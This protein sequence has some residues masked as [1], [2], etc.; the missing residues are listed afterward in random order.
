MQTAAA[1]AQAPTAPLTP[2]LLRFEL[3]SANGQPGGWMAFPPGTVFVDG[4]EKYGGKHSLRFERSETSPGQFSAVMVGTP[5]EFKGTT[6]ELRGWMRKE[7]EGVPSLWM[8]Q[9]AGG[10]PV[11]FIDM[12]AIHPVGAV[13]KEHSI[14]FRLQS[15]ATSLVIGVR[16]VGTGKAWADD[17]QLLVD[18]NPISEVKRVVRPRS[19]MASDLQFVGGSGLIVDRLDAPLIDALSLTGK[20][21]GF[22][23]YHH[24]FI[25]AGNKQWDFELLRRLPAIIKAPQPDAVR[26]QLVE[27]ID[28]LGPIAECKQCVL[29][30]RSN[31]HL[32][33][34]IEWI[35]DAKWLGADLSGRLQAIHR[36]RVP[37]QQFF[38]SLAPNIGNA[39]FE[40][41][42]AYAQVKFPDTGFQ[43][44][45]I[46][47]FWNMIEYWFPYRDLIDE[48][49]DAVLHD[50]L[51]RA[52]QPLDA[53]GFARELMRLAARADDGHANLEDRPSVRQPAGQCQLPLS[54]RYLERQFVVE[55]MLAHT[56]SARPFRK[57]DVIVALDGKKVAEIAREVRD[58]Y[59]ASNEFAR[60]SD[61]AM[62]LTRGECGHV[63]VRVWRDAEITLSAQRVA[64]ATL[65]FDDTT[66]NDRP[67]DTFQMLS[68]QVAYLKLST[69]AA[70]DVR[71]YL[72]S[73]ATARSL[74]VDIR[75]Y[76][77]E[78]VVYTLGNL[79]VTKP[80]QFATVTMG[81]LSDPGAFHF[82]GKTVLHPEQPGFGG[83]VLILVDE[84]SI[85]M[86]EFTAIALRAT[87]RAKVIG[88]Q[89]AG[90]DGDVSRIPMPGG[91]SAAIS[92]IGIF[93]PDRSPT[94]QVGVNLDIECP[95][96][97]A[98]L[99]EGR[100]E[101]LDC[102]LR[103]LAKSP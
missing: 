71:G 65:R 28:A 83:R 31:L 73:A 90:A 56:D 47:R 92:G 103:E 50:T 17:L 77:A 96:T 102:A 57:G 24:P 35:R 25:T 34:H 101:T 4:R 13:W 33:P 84:T 81:T 36:N 18:G 44:L 7:G 100:D 69:I 40:N 61:I 22:L 55:S 12:G 10:S 58:Q 5:V 80:T 46:F 89:T 19:V 85:S 8:R 21:W 26:R 72:D 9:D 86:S 51:A 1:L 66:R 3:A 75:N 79:L 27:W 52:A 20:V 14:S 37:A 74:I 23:K 2:E 30:E 49:W 82:R 11:Q 45:A 91:F 54:L 63:A 97:I 29:F 59:G 39:V 94:Q 64:T 16:F 95:N 42:L 6:V 53:V 67:G 68:P 70:Q 62:N 98:G 41:E 38:V 93:Y 60:M 87:P 88:M 99:R 78:Y 43:I 76:P 15:N 48:D 32:A